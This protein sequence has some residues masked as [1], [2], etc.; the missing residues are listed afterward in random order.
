MNIQEFHDKVLRTII[1]I[2]YKENFKYISFLPGGFEICHD[3]IEK[4]NYQIEI[5]RREKA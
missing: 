4:Q 3:F 2:F 1:E 5:K